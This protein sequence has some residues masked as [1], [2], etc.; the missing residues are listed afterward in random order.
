MNDY[1]YG[2]FYH[3]PVRV[4]NYSQLVDDFGNMVSRD[5]MGALTGFC[6]YMDGNFHDTYACE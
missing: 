3:C 5:T 2:N 1:Y 6:H 4:L